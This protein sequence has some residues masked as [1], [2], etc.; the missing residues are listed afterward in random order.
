MPSKFVF[1]CQYFSLTLRPHQRY[2]FVHW[3]IVTIVIHNWPKSKESV[4]VE[5]SATDDTCLSES[6]P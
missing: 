1:L 6:S 4:L 3:M 5:F 2:F